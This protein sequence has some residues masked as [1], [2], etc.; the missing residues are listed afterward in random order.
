MCIGFCCV[1]VV[2]SP[3]SQFHEVGDPVLWSVKLTLSD[4]FP[5]VGDAEKSATGE[6]KPFETTIRYPIFV[7]ELVPSEFVTPK[8]TLYCP[9]LL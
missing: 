4:A 3:K 5:E 9:G 1:E 8:L 7:T 6:F 2:P